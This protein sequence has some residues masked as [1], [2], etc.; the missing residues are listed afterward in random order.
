MTHYGATAAYDRVLQTAAI[1]T[2]QCFG[3]PSHACHVI[4]IFSEH[5]FSC[6][7]RLWSV[8]HTTGTTSTDANASKQ[9]TLLHG[10][11]TKFYIIF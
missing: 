8:T 11:K 5:G 6:D 3:M 7:H 9:P 2:Y 1:V 4:Y 10:T